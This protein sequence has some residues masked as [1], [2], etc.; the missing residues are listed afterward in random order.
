MI[1]SIWAS[2]PREVLGPARDQGRTNIC[3]AHAVADALTVKTGQHVGAFS[4]AMRYFERRRN[5]EYLLMTPIFNMIPRNIQ[6]GM[7]SETLRSVVEKKICHR[8][9]EF[10]D[11]T[12]HQERFGE[13][14]N[15]HR[16]F[17]ATISP[18][19]PTEKIERL[20]DFGDL[21]MPGL[22]SNI[23][24]EVLDPF[25]SL[26]KTYG[27][28]FDR[29]CQIQVNDYEIVGSELGFQSREE[30]LAM[31]NDALDAGAI[32]IVHYNFQFLYGENPPLIGRIVGL[33]VNTI[34]DRRE[35]QDGKKEYLLR[36]T[37][38]ET[39]RFDQQYSMK[40][41]RGHI[42]ISEEDIKEEVTSVT[43]IL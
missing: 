6:A 22:D 20:K 8:S 29:E 32:P 21:L 4:V 1:S 24:E 12:V 25:L 26:E 30:R 43:Y 39:C 42:W 3:F 36:N 13:L 11:G 9:K 7:A 27:A 10:R 28:W 2:N 35:T 14:M 34:I 31:I 15:A 5:L 41:D 38:C 19:R 37:W 33:H 40:C 16:S 18:Y 23:L 17:R